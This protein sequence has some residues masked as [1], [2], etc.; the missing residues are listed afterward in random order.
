[1]LQLSY[2]SLSEH[3]F[4]NIYLAP[5]TKFKTFNGL[6]VALTSESQQLPDNFSR[7]DFSSS[8]INNCNVMLFVMLAELLVAVC[9]YLVGK[10]TQR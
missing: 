6:N 8:F 10:F 1:M 3:S 9:V 4:L 7:M 5:L 2:F